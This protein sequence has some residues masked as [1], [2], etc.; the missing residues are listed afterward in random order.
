[1]QDL[2]NELYQLR[3]EHIANE[4]HAELLRTRNIEIY[5]RIKQIEAQIRNNKITI[6]PSDDKTHD[7]IEGFRCYICARMSSQICYTCKTESTPSGFCDRHT[8][9]H[10]LERNHIAIWQNTTTGT[11]IPKPKKVIDI[12]ILDKL[13]ARIDAEGFTDEIKAQCKE[14]GI[15]I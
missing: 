4:N 13:L 5:Y 2:L 1:M 10:K 14:L 7:I 8:T 9:N 11:N 6:F 15:K 12:N 3:K